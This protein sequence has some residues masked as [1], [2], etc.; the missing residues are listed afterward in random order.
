MSRNVRI[1][2][3]CEDQ[4]HE[5]FARKFFKKAGWNLRDFRVVRAPT[6]KGAADS[7]VCQRFPDELQA[8]RSK[9]GEKAYL[10]VIL[11]GDAQG[12]DHRKAS[13]NA[14]CHDR[15]VEPPADSDQV[16]VAVPTWNIETWL[17]YLG[18]E[19]VDETNRDYPRLDRPRD[20][21]ALV[22]QLVTMCNKNDL[23]SPHPLSLEDTCVQ[24]RRLFG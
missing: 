7:F 9:R 13:L 19:S 8:L 5:A 15:D 17:A 16:L 10:V 2:L 22:E 18:G 20:C 11:D 14:N 24:Y 3:L 1:V 4:Q 12:V 23:R 21:R 6:A